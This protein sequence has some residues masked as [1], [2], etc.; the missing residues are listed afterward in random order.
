MIWVMA[1]AKFPS[2]STISLLSLILLPSPFIT[3]IH[4]TEPDLVS[5][6]FVDRLNFPF[7]TQEPPQPP[8]LIGRATPSPST[9]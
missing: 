4:I 1:P 8:P 6:A 9:A 5:S 2:A 7:S 3:L